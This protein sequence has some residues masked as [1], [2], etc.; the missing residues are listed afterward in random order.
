MNKYLGIIFW[1]MLVVAGVL[2]YIATDQLEN[3]LDNM[4]SK[5]EDINTMLKE[6]SE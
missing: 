4:E 1:S 6:M 2:G 3:R 5:I